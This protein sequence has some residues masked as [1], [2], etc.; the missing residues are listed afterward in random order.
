MFIQIEITTV[1]NYHCFYCCGR[2]M[3][4]QHM[5]IDVFKGILEKLPRQSLTINLQGE[6]EPLLHPLFKDIVSATVEHGYKPYVITNGTRLPLATI[7]KHFPTI[8]ISIDTLDAQLSDRI[9]RVN[10]TKVLRNLQRLI[11]SG[12]PT[13]NINIHTVNF[14]QDLEPLHCYLNERGLSNHIIQPL[15]IKDDYRS[16]YPAVRFHASVQHNYR[17][18]YIDN[19][20][21]HYFNIN[22]TAM[23]CCF[24]KQPENF[25]SHEH[26]ATSL[27]QQVVPESCRGCRELY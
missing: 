7:N 15:Q 14:G 3:N 19:Q 9:G 8:G 27:K 10:L 5:S 17:C 4:Q 20:K 2:D 11:E 12:Y 21:L 16:P 26:I 1:C 13:A 25:I 22:A 6:G 18:P 24:I 23:P